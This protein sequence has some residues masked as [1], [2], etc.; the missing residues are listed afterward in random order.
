[1]KKTIV[2]ILLAVGLLASVVIADDK[3]VATNVV[4]KSWEPV[5]PETMLKM[6]KAVEGQ[7]FVY[8]TMLSIPIAGGPQVE[9]YVFSTPLH[10]PNGRHWELKNRQ[11]AADQLILIR[12]HQLLAVGKPEYGQIGTLTPMNDTSGV[13]IRW[14]AQKPVKEEDIVVKKSDPR[15]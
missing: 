8:Q 15:P 14:M 13:V 12:K 3:T 6:L 4:E 7:K 1:M 5:Y 10:S 11:F 2:G 9:V